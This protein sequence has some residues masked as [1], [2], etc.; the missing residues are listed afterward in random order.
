MLN[1]ILFYS[2]LTISLVAQT[3]FDTSRKFDPIRSPIKNGRC[4]AITKERSKLLSMKQRIQSLQS[5]N[6]SIFENESL[7][8]AIS[9]NNLRSGNKQLVLL[10]EL[11]NSKILNIEKEIIIQGCPGITF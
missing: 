8:D 1:V 10:E 4:S 6:N 5:R 11:T 3:N 7:P 2:T 9:T